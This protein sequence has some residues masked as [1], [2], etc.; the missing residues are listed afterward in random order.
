LVEHFLGR[1]NQKYQKEVRG[2]DPKVMAQF[3]KY[4]W[5]GNV[6]ELERILEYAFVFVKG[7]VIFERNLPSLDLL[8]KERLPGKKRRE[9]PGE[10]GEVD[11]VRLIKALERAG[12]RHSEAAR[13]LGISRILYGVR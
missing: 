1:L 3:L 6:R 4:P 7:P 2:L 8:M 9:L 12:G 13:I 5:P 11:Q 10:T